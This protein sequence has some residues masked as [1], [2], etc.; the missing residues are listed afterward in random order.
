MVDIVKVWLWF[1]YVYSSWSLIRF[2]EEQVRVCW[3]WCRVCVYVSAERW[4]C[5]FGFIVTSNF[6][7]HQYVSLLLWIC[8]KFPWLNSRLLNQYQLYWNLLILGYLIEITNI[9]FIENPR[10]PEAWRLLNPFN[11]SMDFLEFK[12]RQ[13]TLFKNTLYTDNFSL[14]QL[15]PIS[16]HTYFM[17]I[18][19]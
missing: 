16:S 7:Y 13:F 9:W 3:K 14:V 4:I 5:F 11:V 12:L 19:A 8:T 17:K 18:Q 1:I 6:P 2:Y 10:Q 15:L